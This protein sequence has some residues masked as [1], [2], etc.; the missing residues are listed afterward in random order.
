MLIS[1][2]VSESFKIISA[3]NKRKE[4]LSNPYKTHNVDTILLG[5][6]IKP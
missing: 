3:E 5:Y 6:E 2:L 1:T 4:K